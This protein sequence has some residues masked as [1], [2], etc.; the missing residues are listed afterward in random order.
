MGNTTQKIQKNQQITPKNSLPEPSKEIPENRTPEKVK[1]Q[2][3][4][5]EKNIR[6]NNFYFYVLLTVTF[7]FL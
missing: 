3:P 1:Q 4:I 6:K 5:Y 7:L 2:E